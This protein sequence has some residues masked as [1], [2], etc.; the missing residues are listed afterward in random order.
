MKKELK[1]WNE[2]VLKGMYKQTFARPSR[3][4]K[5]MQNQRTNGEEQSRFKNK[6]GKRLE[7]DIKPNR[8]RMSS[9]EERRETFVELRKMV[10]KWR[11]MK[12]IVRQGRNDC[13]GAEKQKELEFNLI[14]LFNGYKSQM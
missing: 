12:I 7:E 1:K 10:V 8:G 14:K 6:E 2:E 9:N 3:S 11:K 4:E 5:K 13:D